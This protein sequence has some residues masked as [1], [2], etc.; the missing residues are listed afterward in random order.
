MTSQNRSVKYLAYLVSGLPVALASFV[1]LLCGIT[2]SAG[3]AIV[4][5][6][7]PLALVTLDVARQF[8]RFE[9]SRLRSVGVGINARASVGNSLHP[10]EGSWRRGMRV[11]RDPR[12]WRELVHGLVVFRWRSPPSPSRSP[13]RSAR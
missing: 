10:F 11:V 2:V 9:R 7:F 8:A 6:G 5:V 1:L 4:W 12:A 13:G 3:L